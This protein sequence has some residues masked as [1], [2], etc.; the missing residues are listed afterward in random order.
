MQA[1]QAATGAASGRAGAPGAPGADRDEAGGADGAHAGAAVLA[2]I[3]ERIAADLDAPGALMVVDDWA[4]R[5][6]AGQAPGSGPLV[7]AAVDAI[8]GIVL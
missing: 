4:A 5:A 2:A 8:L 1:A 6:I 3:R 7:A